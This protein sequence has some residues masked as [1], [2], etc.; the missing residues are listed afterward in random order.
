MTDCFGKEGYSVVSEETYSWG[1][2]LRNEFKQ[3]IA[4]NAYLKRFAYLDDF[5]RVFVLKNKEGE[6]FEVSVKII[7]G[8]SWREEMSVIIVAKKVCN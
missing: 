4:I 5:Y 3:I 8:W 7:S 2:I 6:Q 1:E